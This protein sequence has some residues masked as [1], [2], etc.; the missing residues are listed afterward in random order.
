MGEIAE[1]MLSGELCEM[2]GV[3][4]DGG[5]AGIPMYCSKECALDRGVPREGIE[6]RIAK[7][8]YE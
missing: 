7:E 1:A 4:I 5:D 8:S 3:P 6:S 2:C